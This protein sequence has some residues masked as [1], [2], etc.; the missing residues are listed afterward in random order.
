MKRSLMVL[1]LALTLV[2]SGAAFAWDGN[3]TFD[4][5]ISINSG[6]M[7]P[8]GSWNELDGGPLG[9]GVSTTCSGPMLPGGSWDMD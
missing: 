9:G 5:G 7:L 6:P 2:F 3:G 1:A 4:G 8:G